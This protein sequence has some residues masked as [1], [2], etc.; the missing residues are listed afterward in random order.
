MLR[1]ATVRKGVFTLLSIEIRAAN[2][3]NQLSEHSAIVKCFLK[4]KIS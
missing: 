2:R 3:G 1:Q 4:T